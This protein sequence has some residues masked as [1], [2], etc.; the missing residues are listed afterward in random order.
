MKRQLLLL[1][2]LLAFVTLFFTACTQTAE[3][4]FVPPALE[5]PA[6]VII[7]EP[8]ENI[9]GAGTVM[10][11]MSGLWRWYDR[12]PNNA[13]FL[14]VSANGTWESPGALPNDLS[15][16]GSFVVFSTYENIYRMSFT[17]EHVSDHPNSGSI[18]IGSL[19]EN[20]LFD[21]ENDR[22]GAELMVEGESNIVW[23]TR[24]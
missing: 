14:E 19:L 9:A 20:Y 23:F 15:F 11:Q 10:S 13:V 22:L 8:R 12:N 24:Q 6:D 18:V 16:G 1:L 5:T 3:A 4:P 7:E 2:S 17:I 21:A